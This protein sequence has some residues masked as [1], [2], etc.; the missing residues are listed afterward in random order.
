MAFTPVSLPLQE[1]LF[2]HFMTDVVTISNANDLLLQDKLED[3]INNLEIDINTLAIGTDNPINYIRTK[4]VIM[5]DDGF[6][7]QTGTP[8]QIIARLSKNLNE[9][10]V[11][12]VDNLTVDLLLDVDALVANSLTIN[13]SLNVDGPVIATDSVELKAAS[14]QSKETVVAALSKAVQTDTFASARLTLTSGSNQN[15]FV[16]LKATTSPDL[17][18]VYD[19]VG[20]FLDTLGPVQLTEFR[21]YLDFDANSPP[22]Q[23][24]EFTI[25]I[26]DVTDSAN[27]SIMSA[28]VSDTIQIKIKPGTNLN[29]TPVAPIILHSGLGSGTD[30]GINPQSTTLNASGVLRSNIP[31]LYGANIS[32]LYILDHLTNDRLVIKSTVGMEFF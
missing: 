31:A 23:N 11:L 2:T 20:S 4:S 5:Q 12:N 29:A 22:A 7:Y 8:N 3:L 19:G 6:I 10:S 28:V 1:A 32:L 30:I 27:N 24:Q 26:V 25:Y 13:D 15:I 16:S 9:E 18:F 21:L 14:I 17:G